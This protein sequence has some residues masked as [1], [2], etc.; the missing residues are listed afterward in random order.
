M[1]RRTAEERF[2]VLQLIEEVGEFLER[3]GFKVP[4]G[5][6]VLGLGLILMTL[7]I[8]LVV[9][10]ATTPAGL[11]AAN[12]LVILGAVRYRRAK[13]QEIAIYVGAFL[14]CQALAQV[15]LRQRIP[16]FLA[17]L[18]IIGPPLA[19]GAVTALVNT[20]RRKI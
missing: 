8:G 6:I 10:G 19:I 14:A 2:F 7:G 1:A 17:A 9:F 16:M 4:L 20:L 5:R 13:W 3:L 18:W 11:I 15:Y 12:A